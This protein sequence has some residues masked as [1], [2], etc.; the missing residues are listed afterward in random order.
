MKTKHHLKSAISGMDRRGYKA[1]K[2]LEGEWL[3]EDYTFVID[4]AQGDPFA[5]PSRVR[6]LL[7]ADYVGLDPAT[8]SNSSRA[9]GTEALL[10]RAFADVARRESKRRGTGHS[11]EIRIVAPG[12][13]VLPQTAMLLSESG[14][15]EVRF[16]VGLPARGRRIVAKEALALLL[17]DVPAVI[18]L[19]LRASVHSADQLLEAACLNEDADHLRAQLPELGL[20]AFVADDASLP[21]ASGDSDRPLRSGEVVPFQSPPA[22]RVELEAPNA[23]HVRGMGIPEGVTL[24]VGGGF[25]GKSTLLQAL[26]WGVYNHRPRDGREHVVSDAATVKIRA[27]DGRSVSGVNISPFIGDL[28][29]GKPTD[30]FTTSNASGS[31]S[32]AASIMEAVE[33]G[34]K[35]LLIDEDTAATNFMI[36][37]RRMQELVPKDR[38]PITPFVDRVRDLYE[39]HGVSTILVI[40]GSGDYLDV[41]DT[42]IAMDEYRPR[43]VT[44]KAMSIAQELRTGRIREVPDT[45]APPTSRVPD[46]DSVDSRQGRWKAGIKVR[47]RGTIHF[48]KET[49]DLSAVEQ[50]VSVAQTRTVAAALLLARDRFMDGERSIAAIL[51]AVDAIIAAEGLDVLDDRLVGHFAAFR[52][53]ELAAALNRLRSLRVEA[54]ALRRN[55]PAPAGLG[56]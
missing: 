1:Y 4:H 48:G 24:I 20:V 9:R 53:F 33:I 37:D 22:L 27:E 11:G 21:R 44:A 40:G 31:T 56:A 7:P 42:V 14:D 54:E 51:D 3:F 23:G 8:Y 10:A 41:A 43:H 18:D 2:D 13:E 16:T 39:Q 29:L 38:E 50:I 46:P 52:R 6:A 30:A 32:Q 26:Q 49:I 47:D 28:P 15:L 12:Q 17:E 34:A 55:R 35:V 19:S 25:H 45:F 36:R 5:Q